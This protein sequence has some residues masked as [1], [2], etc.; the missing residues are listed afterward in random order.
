MGF[1]KTRLDAADKQELVAA[2]HSYRRGL[3]PLKVPLTLLQHH[4]RRCVVPE[5]VHAQVY[6]DPYPS[7]L[8]LR[9]QV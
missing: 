3:V 5:W 6:L 9:N 4:I 2:V 8:M 1:L 7:D